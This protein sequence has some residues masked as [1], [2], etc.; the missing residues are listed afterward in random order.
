MKSKKLIKRWFI[1]RNLKANSIR[2]FQGWVNI[3]MNKHRLKQTSL[4]EV[5]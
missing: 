5:N 2:T 1:N 4:K 3:S